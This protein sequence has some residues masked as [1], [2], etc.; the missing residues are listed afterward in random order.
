MSAPEV[1]STSISGGSSQNAS[2]RSSHV[3][4]PRQRPSLI[5]G[6]STNEPMPN[7]R[8]TGVGRTSSSPG[9]GT[10]RAVPLAS[11]RW[12]ARERAIGRAAGSVSSSSALSPWAANGIR[13]LVAGT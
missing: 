12:K 13:T 8:A 6:T 7:S 1:A 9:S 2:P 4:K 10:K 3:M 5:S 11:A